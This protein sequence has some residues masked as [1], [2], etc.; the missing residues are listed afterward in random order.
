MAA[1]AV[2]GVVLGIGYLRAYYGVTLPDG[3]PLATFWVIIVLALAVRRLP[4]ALRACF[5][6]MQQIQSRSKK[7][8]KTSAPR[9]HA[10]CGASSYR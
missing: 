10:P 3:T 7:R 5:A 2:P 4:Y 1:L 8:P 9:R 6:A